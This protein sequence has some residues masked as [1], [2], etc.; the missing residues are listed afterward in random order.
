[1]DCEA[2]VYSIKLRLFGEYDFHQWEQGRLQALKDE[3]R[4][5]AREYIL[6]VNEAEYIEHLIA[7]YSVEPIEF[8]FAA[9]EATDIERPVSELVWGPNHRPS[10]TSRPMPVYTFHIPF[11]GFPDLLHCTPTTRLLQTLNVQADRSLGRIAFDV[12]CAENDAGFVN[13]Q[14]QENGRFIREQS[15][16][17][18]TDTDRYN[19]AIPTRVRELFSAR[20]AELMRQADV[21][22][23]LVVPLRKNA[24]PATFAVPVKSPK[25]I[26]PRPEAPVSGSHETH[27]T[28]DVSL[29]AEILQLVHDFGMQMER[30]PGTYQ[31]KDEQTLRDHFLLM[32]QPHFG[33]EGS[34]T[35]ETFNAAGKTDILLRYENRNLFIAE[36]KFWQGAKKHSEAIDQLLSYLTWRDS[37]AAIVY[38]IRAKEIVQPLRAIEEST[39]QHAA[40]VK[41]TERKEESWFS[42]EFHLPGDA[43]R[44]VK[45][46]ILCFHLPD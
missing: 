37:K 35:G 10:S 43:R 1:M 7:T 46:A 42:Y 30:L 23:K 32:L 2:I 24:A 3:I 22:S 40:F 45:V 38:F 13:S 41:F 34:A 21:A 26:F 5:E 36:F 18:R 14:Y 17:L 16:H 28:L 6:N 11:T 31:G 29:Y 9:A 27:P 15:S 44:L 33:M 20:K 4:K 25:R 8:D 39:P 12:V 19:A